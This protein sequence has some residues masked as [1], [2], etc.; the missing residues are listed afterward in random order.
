M[1]KYRI[2]GILMFVG[3]ESM[4]LT[5]SA[6]AWGSGWGSIST[7]SVQESSFGSGWQSS[8]RATNGISADDRTFS[9]V[10]V[11]DYNQAAD[12]LKGNSGVVY[13]GQ[14]VTN[15]V[16]Q[17]SAVQNALQDY[18]SNKIGTVHTSIT[19]RG[20]PEGTDPAQ[21]DAY[22]AQ[23]TV[24]SAVQYSRSGTQ[25]YLA[26]DYSK[27][28]KDLGMVIRDVDSEAEINPGIKYNSEVQESLKVAHMLLAGIDKEN[29]DSNGALSHINTAIEYGAGDAWTYM[30][31]GTAEFELGKFDEAVKSFDKAETLT[32]EKDDLSTIAYNKCLSLQGAGRVDEAITLAEKSNEQLNESRFMDLKAG[33]LQESGKTDE[34]LAV[35]NKQIESGDATWLTYYSKGATLSESQGGKDGD[36]DVL[37]EAISCYDKA[38]ELSGQKVHV[39]TNI[40]GEKS[41]AMQKLGLPDSETAPVCNKVLELIGNKDVSG[42]PSL[43]YYKGVA[44]QGLGK[45]DEAHTLFNKVKDTANQDQELKDYVND[46]EGDF[47]LQSRAKYFVED[48]IIGTVNWI[49]SGFNEILRFELTAALD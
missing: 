46:R 12:F 38:I 18:L 10:I 37:R 14:S 45:N 8:G 31:K 9:N 41:I 7:A 19:L 49:S 40:Y 35:L 3:L 23:R 32:N 26:G 30:V 5:V 44:L 22:L 29:E 2:A 47:P 13:T 11:L 36:P 28:A 33:F 21:W 16:L 4:C 1:G 24:D 27:A 20:Y 6:Y 42:N 39:Q 25:A 17:N 48:N 34:A 43:A 15:E